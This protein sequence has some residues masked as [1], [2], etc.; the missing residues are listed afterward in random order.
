MDNRG[1]SNTNVYENEA[2]INNTMA[3]TDETVI[4]GQSQSYIAGGPRTLYHTQKGESP[5]Y[6][7]C[8]NVLEP[9]VNTEILRSRG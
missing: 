6:D 8:F 1:S 5:V 2:F 3:Y 9:T 7:K 4:G